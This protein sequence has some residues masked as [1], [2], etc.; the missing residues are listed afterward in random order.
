LLSNSRPPRKAGEGEEPCEAAVKNLRTPKRRRE[1]GTARAAKRSW[2]E[3]GGAVGRRETN[4]V[5][6]KV[7]SSQ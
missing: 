1:R 2:E 5:Q 6:Q 4:H 7:L 3:S